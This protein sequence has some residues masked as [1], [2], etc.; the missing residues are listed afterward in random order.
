M[1]PAMNK[2]IAIEI[3]SALWGNGRNMTSRIFAEIDPILPER[4]LPVLDRLLLVC[5]LLED[6]NANKRPA[7]AAFRQWWQ[8]RID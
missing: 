2:Q 3:V 4:S 8:S 1:F 7:F 5:G 6:Y